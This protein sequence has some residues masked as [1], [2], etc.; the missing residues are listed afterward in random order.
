MN[1]DKKHSKTELET[2]IRQGNFSSQSSANA[3]L[4]QYGL[5]AQLKDDGSADIMD[6]QSRRVATVQFQ[7][8]GSDVN[9]ISSIN[10]T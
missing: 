5:S 3:Y 10:I 6:D 7:G 9:S 1:S 4:Q 8:S 2:I